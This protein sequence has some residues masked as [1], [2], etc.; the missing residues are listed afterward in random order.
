M[1]SENQNILTNTKKQVFINQDE[2]ATVNIILRTNGHFI[3]RLTKTIRD[4]LLCRRKFRFTQQC[5]RRLLI[6]RSR[7]RFRV[8]LW[9]FSL[10]KNYSKIC[11][12]TV[13]LCFFVLFPCSVLCYFPRRP[14]HFA[15]H[16]TIDALQSC[17][18]PYMW[19]TEASIP[20]LR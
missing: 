2:P 3:T 4:F 9:I 13:F 20:T 15:N 1:K 17:P 12:N 10:V 19:S 18:C 16:R 5:R 7:V 11:S 6:N 14:L 8:M